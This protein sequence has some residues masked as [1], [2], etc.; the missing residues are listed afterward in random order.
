MRAVYIS[1]AQGIRESPGMSGADVMVRGETMERTRRDER[2][3]QEEELERHSLPGIHMAGKP[4]P[5][6][7]EPCDEQDERS[8]DSKESGE[9]Q[10][11]QH[12][13]KD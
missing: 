12:A 13:K 10:H 8:A 7:C 9:R 6:A 1:P 4:M 3:D 2:R 11:D 5:D